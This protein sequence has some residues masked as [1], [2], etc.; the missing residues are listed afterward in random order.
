[1][2]NCSAPLLHHP[3]ECE[4]PCPVSHPAHVLSLGAQNWYAVE[5]VRALSIQSSEQRSDRIG[6]V[7]HTAVT[8]VSGCSQGLSTGILGV[9]SADNGRRSL[10]IG[11]SVA[12]TWYRGVSAILM[13]LR[14]FGHCARHVMPRS[15]LSVSRADSSLSGVRSV[16][17]NS[18]CS[19]AGSMMCRRSDP[20]PWRGTPP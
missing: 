12:V 19:V 3:S 8:G 1:M 2:G 4:S 14:T 9:F 5:T 11:R 17:Q 15:G 20:T 6:A 16:R 18:A 7:V 10:T 13:P